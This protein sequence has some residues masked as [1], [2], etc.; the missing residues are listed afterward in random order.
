M[1]GINKVILIGHIGKEPAIRRLAN[2]VAVLTFP[3]ATSEMLQKAGQPTE[4]TEWHNVVLWRALA[5]NAAQF[6]KKGN[7]VYIEGKVRTRSFTDKAGIRKFITEIV[8]D[9]YSLL[10]QKS[11]F[12][13]QPRDTI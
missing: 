13:E 1:S 11:D 8:A 3:F 6:L 4:V 7:L 2:D 10:G 12:E 9:H 5:E